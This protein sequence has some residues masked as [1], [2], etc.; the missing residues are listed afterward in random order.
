MLVRIVSV[1]SAT[2][3]LILA[4]LALRIGSVSDGAGGSWGSALAGLATLCPL[5]YFATC[6]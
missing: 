3:F 4:A 2:W 1:P 6:F 5:I